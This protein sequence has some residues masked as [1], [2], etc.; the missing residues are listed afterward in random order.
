[1]SY[2]IVFIQKPFEQTWEDA[3]RNNQE[4]AREYE[5]SSPP[6][7]PS[8]QEQWDGLAGLFQQVN[9]ALTREPG[10]G[11]MKLSDEETGLQLTLKEYEIRI[12]VPFRH[13]GRAAWRIMTHANKYA[14]IIERETG[15]IGYDNERGAAFLHSEEPVRGPAEFLSAKSKALH[16]DGSL[17]S[18]DKPWWKFWE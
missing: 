13:A 7:D 2:D 8:T 16:P 9:P 14:K 15:L 1:M 17:G 18:S 4:T 12:S 3:L 6:A 5:T 10:P 11:Y